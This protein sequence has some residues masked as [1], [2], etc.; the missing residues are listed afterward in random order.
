M[1]V[2]LV[3]DRINKFGGAER[4]LLAL[5][6]LYPQAPIYTLVHNPD[7]ARWSRGIKVV[8]SFFNKVKCLRT[9][10]EL[11]P[12]VAGYGFES[13]NFNRYDLVI[14]VTSADAKA[15]VTKPGT[16][17]LCYCLTPTRYLWTDFVEYQ[18]N[19]KMRLLPKIIKDKLRLQD[20]LYA[21]RPDAYLAIS[22]EV[23]K[24]IK[25]HYHRP[26]QVIYPAIDDK[27]Y[28]KKKPLDQNKRKSYLLVSRL[29]P[30]KKA[31]LVIKAFNQLGLPLTVV[32]TGSQ[33]R[34]LRRLAKKNITFVGQVN[35]QQLISYYRHAK[36]VIF[37]QHE[38]FG[39]VP[40]EAQACGTPVIA[41]AQGGALETVIDGQTG[42]LFKQQTVAS[43]IEAVKNFHSGQI[44]IS[45]SAC[46]HQAEKFSLGRFNR[47]FSDK[48]KS[49]WKKHLNQTT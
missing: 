29:V 7:T 18:Q 48:V 24:R 15:I 42:V 14:S 12:L 28:S 30:Y 16:F 3:Y 23:K 26:A 19:I 43:L 41:Y 6:H 33:A 21:Q 38:D 35:D 39:L 13:F 11:L 44:K 32:G 27:F 9:R 10:H 2:A 36:A 1:K 45:S 17:H 20:H 40:L 34:C 25:R 47:Q 4:V 8:P 31:D 5:H 49:L 22:N 46:R 37:P